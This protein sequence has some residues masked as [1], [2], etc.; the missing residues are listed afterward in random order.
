[1]NSHQKRIRHQIIKITREH[2]C[3]SGNVNIF[4]S[5]VANVLAALESP[6]VKHIGASRIMSGVTY[7][8]LNAY[9]LYKHFEGR[10]IALNLYNHLNKLLTSS[11][12][13]KFVF[14]SVSQCA[15][16]EHKKIKWPERNPLNYEVVGKCHD[17]STER[18]SKSHDDQITGV[19]SLHDQITYWKHLAKIR[20]NRL[21]EIVKLAECDL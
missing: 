15:E 21:S 18:K 3:L 8:V 16:P 9:G 6:G 12:P 5:D 19:K 1:M 14:C 7:R 2:F 17:A 11:F 20:G 4:T 13:E 10:A